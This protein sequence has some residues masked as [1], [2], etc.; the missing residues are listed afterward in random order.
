MTSR[1][2][3][4]Q[5]ILRAVE[6]APPTSSVTAVADLL[7]EQVDAHDVCFLIT[8]LAGEALWRLPAVWADR[9]G[10]ADPVE[11]LPG[12]VYDEV[13]RT[14]KLHVVEAHAPDG[15]KRGGYLVVT[16]VTTRGDAIGALELVTQ[17]P[18]TP[19]EQEHIAQAAQ[20]LSYVVTIN[21]R[22]TD[23]FEWRRRTKVP[24]LAAEIQHNLLPAALAVEAGQAT[25]A[26]ALEPAG[27]IAGDTFDYSL[28]EQA[29]HLSITDAMGHGVESALLAS[30]VAGALRQTRRAAL[31]LPEQANAAHRAL[32]EYGRG[33]TAT[34]Q[35]L[36]VDLTSGHALLVNAGHPWPLRLRAGQVTELEP[37]VDMPFGNPWQD[38]YQVQ[39]ISLYPGDRLV[40]LT[41]GMLERNTRTL[42][43]PTVIARDTALHP[44]QAVRS[45][46]QA[47]RAATDG[48]LLDDATVVCL[49]WYGPGS[50][51][52]T[53][54]T[55]S[56]R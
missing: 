25:V 14:Q 38:S 37:Q 42:D 50:S 54:A 28:D 24:S 34:G 52:R 33:G 9:E 5:E 11:P 7:A 45:M 36:W 16:P 13:L 18:P 21:R 1:E 27:D 6:Q 40:F 41:D 4:L 47:L 10:K 3:N 55:E 17:Q 19:S 46:V 22:F 48:E 35:M 23:L 53:G 20:A 56:R 39:E 15:Y 29:L 2:L 51:Q 12:T 43:L 44:R 32:L 26:G 30:L 8:D 49:D 31:P